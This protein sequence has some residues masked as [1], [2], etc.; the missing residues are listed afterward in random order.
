MNFMWN[1]TADRFVVHFCFVKF[2]FKLQ[3]FLHLIGLTISFL[4]AGTSGESI[5]EGK[6]PG[7]NAFLLL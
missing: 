2:G 5:Y 3:K 4:C 6:F 7:E 1:N